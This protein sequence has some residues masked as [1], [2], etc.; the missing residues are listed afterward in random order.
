MASPIATTAT[1]TDRDCDNIPDRVD[2]NDRANVRDMDCDGIQD[3]NDPYDDRGYR[4]IRSYS[5]PRYYAPASY[6]SSY[7][8]G[9]RWDVGSRMPYGYYDA[10]YGVDY[11]PYG[12]AAPP[13]GYRWSRVGSDAYLVNVTNGLIAQAVYSLFR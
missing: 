11:R 8:Y 6:S 5:A 13:Y 1:T 4:A 12:L 9:T 2:Q 7:T 3:W 10:R